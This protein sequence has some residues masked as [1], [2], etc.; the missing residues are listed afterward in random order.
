M[1]LGLFMFATAQASQTSPP[2]L[3]GAPSTFAEVISDCRG[4]EK[5]EGV[6]RGLK[7][8]LYSDRSASFDASPDGLTCEFSC[9]VDQMDDQRSCTLV[10]GSGRGREAPYL[11]ILWGDGWTGPAVS[12]AHGQQGYPQ[13]EE[14]LRVDQNA[15]FAIDEDSLFSGQ[16]ASSIINQLKRG[17]RVRLRYYDWP[18]NYSHDSE[19]S[20]K[21]FT[22]VWDAITELR[23]R[24]D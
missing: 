7:Y 6:W 22:A 23:K 15:A 11:L 20:L 1:I 9:R 16:R 21:G 3:K 5:C 2:S 8:R 19:L 12:V 4:M 24:R 13:T 18:Y 17:E 10:G 14:L